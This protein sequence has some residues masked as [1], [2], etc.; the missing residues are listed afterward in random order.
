MNSLIFKKLSLFLTCLLIVCCKKKDAVEEFGADE[1]NAVKITDYGVVPNDGQDDTQAFQTA[2]DEV[3]KK[4]GGTILVPNG[5]YTLDAIKSVF[6]KS[7]ITLRLDKEAYLTAIPNDKSQYRILIMVNVENVKITGG[8]IQGERRN[9]TG[10]GGEWGM[11]IAVYGGKNITIENIVITDCWGDGIYISANVNR[12]EN[13][14]VR[15]IKCFDNRRQGLSIISADNVLVTDSEF[16]RTAGTL[17]ECGID[18]EPNTGDKVTRVVIRNCIFNENE[19]SGVLVS[20]GADN[21]HISDVLV[22]NNRFINNRYWAGYIVGKKNSVQVENIRFVNNIFKGNILAAQ[23]NSPA[24]EVY[25][26]DICSHCTI[27]PN[28]IED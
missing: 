14:V 13:V 7:N 21:C 26:R 25:I 11:G 16:S 20:A 1:P 10:S 3:A 17:P 19:K 28:T 18:I 12:S 5:H 15:N 6:L 4:G 9:H 24:N 8:N 22:E 2:I 23:N 27:S